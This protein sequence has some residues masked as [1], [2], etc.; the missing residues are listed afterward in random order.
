MPTQRKVPRGR[1]YDKR[2]IA[3]RLKALETF[4]GTIVQFARKEGLE[5][6]ALV[7]ACEDAFPEQWQK[8]A[9]THE[10]PAEL[11]CPYCSRTFLPNNANQSF[12]SR[13]CSER[14]RT[15]ERYFGGKR[16]ETIGLSEGT[17]QLCRAKPKRGLQSHHVVGKENDPGN[18][19]LLCLCSG[20]HELVTIASRRLFLREEQGWQR[21]RRLVGLRVAGVLDAERSLW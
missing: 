1:G 16:R 7:V 18:E 12:C 4:K 3:K 19:W 13:Q 21:L 20:C 5:A 9:A 10:L 2:S 11:L 6:N 8:Y 14:A 17:C 15:D